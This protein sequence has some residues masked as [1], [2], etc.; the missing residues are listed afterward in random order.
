MQALGLVRIPKKTKFKLKKIQ[1]KKKM[2]LGCKNT[3]KCLGYHKKYTEN[4][5]NC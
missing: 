4:S 5:L 2:G 1:I 3:E